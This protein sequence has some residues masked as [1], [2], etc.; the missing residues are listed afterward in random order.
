MNVL[1]VG[2]GI[3]PLSYPE[4]NYPAAT[5]F[6][7]CEKKYDECFCRAVAI[8]SGDK[9]ILF[10]AYDLSDQPEVPELE[11]SI[12]EKTGFPENDIV[13]SVTHNHTS[14][15]D[16]GSRNW[17]PENNAAFRIAFMKIEL[18][19]SLRAASQAVSNMQPAS[20]GYGE[21]QSKINEN[22]ITGKSK[23]GLINDSE[24][25]GYCDQTLDVIE[26]SDRKG[27][28]IAAIMNHCTHAVFCMSDKIEGK[29]FTSGNFPG[30]ASRFVEEYYGGGA[31]AVWTSGAAGNQRPIFSNRLQYA[32]TDGYIGKVSLPEGSD[33]MMMEQTGRQ[34]GVDAVNCI[35]SIT[36]GKEDIVIK[37]VK[38]SILLPNQKRSGEQQLSNHGLG[39]PDNNHHKTGMK[40]ENYGLGM[41]SNQ[42]NHPVEKIIPEFADDPE[43]STEL[44]MELLM[45]GD[46]AI[47]CMGAEPFCQ[48]GRDIKKALPAAHTVVVT[49]TPGFVGDNPHAVGYIVD[50]ASAN[51]ESPKCF[52]NLKP[53]FYDEMIVKC[54]MDMYGE[55]QE[56]YEDD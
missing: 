2:A 48:I 24:G 36:A 34:H 14:P 28:L 9:K 15:C 49:H 51:S 11:K 29:S 38:K 22:E 45:L 1:R 19:A 31:V 52:R 4:E 18:E 8:E 40:P 32:Y 6:A 27:K 39:G 30:I 56:G 25:I 41:H 35:N 43:H 47:I 3:T 33:R 7:V 21:Y 44:K 37:H 53:G 13:L 55:I 12:S 17:D 46:I 50:K 5:Q 26:F 20:I 23:L 54:A 16:R 42:I 10:M